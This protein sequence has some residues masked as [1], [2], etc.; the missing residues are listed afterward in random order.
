MGLDIGSNWPNLCSDLAVEALRRYGFDARAP[1]L[2][3]G[4][5]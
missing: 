4:G 5:P 3:L 1:E 2:I